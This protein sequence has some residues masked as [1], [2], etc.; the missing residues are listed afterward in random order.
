MDR[1]GQLLHRPS[2]SL[3]APQDRDWW[4][5]FAELVAVHYILKEELINSV[6]KS[7]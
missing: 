4:P 3:I 1:A 6:L 2:A 7:I 5:A